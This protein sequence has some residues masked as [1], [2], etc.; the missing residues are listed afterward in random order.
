MNTQ[1]GQKQTQNKSL[2]CGRNN[3]KKLW[4]RQERREAQNNIQVNN[5]GKHKNSVHYNTHKRNSMQLSRLH[6]KEYKS[7]YKC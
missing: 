4:R 7:I 6:T 1:G 5:E 2:S 3:D